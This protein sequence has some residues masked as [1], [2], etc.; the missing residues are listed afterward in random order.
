MYSDSETLKAYISRNFQDININSMGLR[1][2]TLLTLRL[3][4]AGIFYYFRPSNC[5]IKTNKSVDLMRQRP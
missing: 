2:H 1:V 4:S 3:T 5:Q